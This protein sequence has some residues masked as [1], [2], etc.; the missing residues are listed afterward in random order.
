[1]MTIFLNI[2]FLFHIILNFVEQAGAK[3]DPEMDGVN[4]STN[5]GFIFKLYRNAIFIPHCCF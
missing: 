4:H 2:A 5:L 3:Q 1:M